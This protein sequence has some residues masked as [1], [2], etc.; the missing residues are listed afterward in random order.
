MSCLQLKLTIPISGKWKGGFEIVSI[1]ISKV[2][3]LIFCL[4]VSSAEISFVSTILGEKQKKL[5]KLK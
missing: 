4:I 2:L 5:F 3:P 1:N